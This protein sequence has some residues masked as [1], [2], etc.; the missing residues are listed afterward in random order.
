MAR[1]LFRQF[2]GA[3]DLQDVRMMDAWSGHGDVS[4]MGRGA[5]AG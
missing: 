2:D 4:E 1:G 5:D 3:A